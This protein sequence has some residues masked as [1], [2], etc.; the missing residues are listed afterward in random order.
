MGIDV[1]CQIDLSEGRQQNGTKSNDL[2]YGNNNVVKEHS[3]MV[4][5]WDSHILVVPFKIMVVFTG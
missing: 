4:S 2:L 5:R 1:T 3:M